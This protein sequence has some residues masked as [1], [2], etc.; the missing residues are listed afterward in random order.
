MFSVVSVC[1]FLHYLC[2]RS[3]GDPLV[4][5]VHFRFASCNHIGIPFSYPHHMEIPETCSNLF[6][7]SN[8]L[9]YSPYL[10]AS[11]Q[12]CLLVCVQVWVRDFAKKGTSFLGQ[13]ICLT[14]VTHA[15]CGIRSTLCW[16]IPNISGSIKLL[17]CNFR[18]WF[19]TT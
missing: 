18:L 15:K 2:H 3:Y 10:L 5:L 1:H 6:T 7:C 4:K 16:K 19:E 9:T 13:N 12:Y 14:S 11:R 17:H 8:W